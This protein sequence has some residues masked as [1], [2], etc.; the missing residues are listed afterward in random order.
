MG[1]VRTAPQN[2]DLVVPGENTVNLN[3]PADHPKF[4]WGIPTN[5]LTTNPDL[6]QN[7]GW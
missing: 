2:N 7:P 3:V 5:D 6:V 1:V 4:I